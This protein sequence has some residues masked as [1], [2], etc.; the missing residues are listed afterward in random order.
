MKRIFNNAMNYLNITLILIKHTVT[1]QVLIFTLS[2]LWLKAMPRT[3]VGPCSVT[4]GEGTRSV[5]LECVDVKTE[6]VLNDDA[7]QGYTI[8]KQQL[9]P[10][11]MPSCHFPR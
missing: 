6:E 10:C 2:L 8:T 11:H 9:E 7:C 5:Q 4:C 3:K 1:F